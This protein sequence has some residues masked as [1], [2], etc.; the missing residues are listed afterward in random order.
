MKKLKLPRLIS[1]GMIVQ[2]HKRA[3]IWG[4]D[5]PGRTVT[6]TF[7]NVE[8]SGVADENGDWEIFLNELHWGGD[9][10]MYIRDDAGEEIILADVMIG[11]V[12]VCSG[13]SNMELPMRRVIDR[14]PYEMFQC[15][16]DCVRTFKITEHADFHAPVKNV[17]T[18]EWKSASKDTVLDFSAIGYY[19]AKELYQLTGIPIGVIDASLGGSRIES[20][21]GRDM[22][23][24][25]RDLLALADKY[26]DD[27]FVKKRLER[28]E[29]RTLA[30]HR[31]L[32]RRDLGL[33][34]NW[35]QKE[36]DV[37]EWKDV[38][39]PFFFKDTELNGFIGSVWFR[40]EFTV[41]KEFA[42]KEEKLWLGTIVDSDTVYVNGVQVGHTDY[43]Y[44]PRKYVIPAGVLQEGSNTIV[45]QVKSEIGQGRF[46]D[47]KKYAVFNKEEEVD[48]TGVWKYRIGAACEMIKETDFVNWKPTGLYNGMMAPCHKYTIAGV[49]WYQGESATRRP[50][51]Y[52]DLMK[53]LIQGYREKWK[54]EFP[55]FYVQL[56]NFS[57]E[58]YDSDRDETFSDWPKIREQQRRALKIPNT[59]MTVAIDSGEDNDL[60]PVTKEAVAFRI[61]MQAA[62]RIYH[63]RVPGESPLIRKVEIKKTGTDENTHKI[64][65]RILLRFR[66]AEKL[67]ARAKGKGDVIKDFEI[68][69]GDGV[70]HTANAEIDANKIILTCE[71]D[72]AF[73]KEVRYCYNNTYKGALIYNEVKFPM[74]PFRVHV[75]QKILP[76]F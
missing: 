69:D 62:S 42:E 19:F 45:I 27:E 63:K 44:P 40:R 32:D 48:L 46:T 25:C 67:Y 6:I 66:Y 53:R 65:W 24:G 5:E 64:S 31:K 13:Q 57:A 9:Y 61:A 37:S 4:E 38:E 59:G 11:D 28:N 75:R 18:G 26:S 33:Q 1:D 58:I 50:G 20:W 51:R 43:Q 52:Y 72:A 55:F 41:S 16:N 30:W 60:H 68:L 49:V 21:M 15:R 70:L 39:I 71:T 34:E 14:Y 47:G 36:L 23:E 7:V 12:W 54:D 56:P 22:L 73:L 74:S 29:R 76:K 8:Y 35:M 2:H 10:K 17:L 3:R